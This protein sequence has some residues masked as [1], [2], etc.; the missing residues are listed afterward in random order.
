MT[1]SH[2]LIE[3]LRFIDFLLDRFGMFNR[4]DIADYFA[5]SIVQGSKDTPAYI[6]HA[7]GNIAYD[8]SDRCYR[9]TDAYAR[10]WP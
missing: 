7:P 5:L 10:V 4:A 2:A 9:R 3:R 8:A 6:E 1:L